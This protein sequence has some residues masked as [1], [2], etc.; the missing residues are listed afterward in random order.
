MRYLEASVT[1]INWLDNYALGSDSELAA[2]SDC[3]PRKKLKTSQSPATTLTN[4]SAEAE[5]KCAENESTVC[6]WDI[7]VGL[8]ILGPAT[9]L[10]NIDRLSTSIFRLKTHKDRS[11]AEGIPFSIVFYVPSGTVASPLVEF[12]AHT[13]N[14]DSAKLLF[15]LAE[16]TKEKSTLQTRIEVV[17]DNLQCTSNMRLN[18]NMVHLAW[19][20]VAAPLQQYS[21]SSIKLANDGIFRELLN[22]QYPDEQNDPASVSSFYGIIRPPPMSAQSAIEVALKT[23]LMRY[24]ANAVAWMISRERGA[25]EQPNLWISYVD[26]AQQV[27]FL[28]K[29]LGLIVQANDK[30]SA[31]ET[32]IRGGLLSDEMGLGKTLEVIATVLQNPRLAVDPNEKTDAFTQNV[33]REIRSTLIVTPA[34]ILQQWLDEIE[35][36]SSL[37]AHYYQGMAKTA[38][39]EPDLNQYDIVITS[40]AVLS[41]E[42]YFAAP[43]KSKRTL[44]NP[45]AYTRRKCP[46][47]QYEWWRVVMVRDSSMI[48]EGPS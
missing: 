4:K 43:I 32:P 22:S 44:R 33:V 42:L 35:K 25:G 34:P 6:L 45:P 37:R 12:E 16:L 3:R 31:I 30:V 14:E 13:A 23:K 36:H 11:S 20:G 27:T 47:V 48:D 2:N 39:S 10:S 46:L 26:E 28:Q 15:S 29:E 18:A 1:N 19:K 41:A 38:D 21:S 7:E 24:Q 8:T 5:A 17:Y 9:G 40:Y